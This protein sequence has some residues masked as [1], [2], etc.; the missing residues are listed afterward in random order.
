[1]RIAL[2]GAT[3]HIG[4]Y[5]VPLL[6]QAGHDVVAIARGRSA[7]YFPDASWRDVDVRHADRAALERDGGFGAW[8]ASLQ[9]EVV[10]DLICYTPDSAR[11]LL[12]GLQGRGTHL[13]HCGSVWVY[14]PRMG[15]LQAETAPRAPVGVYA[16]YK[17]Q[18]EALLLGQSAVPVTILHPGQIVG[19][20]WWPVNPAGNL[21]PR[22][23][24][25]LARGQPVALPGNGVATFHFAHAAD[26]AA[27]F[28]RAIERREVAV[29]ECF[30]VASG[31]PV[32]MAAY[33]QAVAQQY[34]QGWRA[35]GAEGPSWKA[36]YSAQD[37]MFGEFFANYNTGCNVG[38][39]ARVLGFTARYGPLQGVQEAVAELLAPACF[40][41]AG[42][43]SAA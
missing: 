42:A 37:A 31:A 6:V 9:A 10:I 3:G 28:V 20:Q 7:P 33:A 30:N 19:A 8:I 5:L 25:R 29:G 22:V 1:M 18:I 13:L 11:Q 32:S 41:H 39:A 34:G 15:G 2:I 14:G 38:K 4:S 17:A 36:H 43:P 23:L 27:C 12:E 21:D 26:I 35:S 24:A 16:T 40:P